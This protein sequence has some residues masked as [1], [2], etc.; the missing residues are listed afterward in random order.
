MKSI[1][2]LFI[3]VI[4][5]FNALLQSS[6]NQPAVD[7]KKAKAAVSAV[8]P[9]RSIYNFTD[10]FYSQDNQP[11]Q[12]VS[13]KD[14]PVVLSMIFTSCQYACPKMTAGIKNIEDSL[15]G[16]ERNKAHYVLVSFDSELDTPAKLKQF[17][18]EKG[19]DSNWTLLH[20]SEE[21]VK[22]LSVLLDIKYEKL[23]LGSYDHSNKKLLLDK[24]G[25]IV[26]TEEGLDAP[27]LKIVEQLRKQL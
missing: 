14:K 12:L 23:G 5:L 11:L 2:R 19:L 3:V 10:T 18:K 20:G 9:E 25:Q 26:Y 24:M 13:F 17:A 7:D 1:C 15:S 8:L 21:S 6:C 4:M 16:S 22:S 27:D